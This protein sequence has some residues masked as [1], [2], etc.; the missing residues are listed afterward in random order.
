MLLQMTTVKPLKQY[1]QYLRFSFMLTP[2]CNILHKEAA[3]ASTSF[4]KNIL[5]KRVQI[6]ELSFFKQKKKFP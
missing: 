6:I 5:H 2:V 3:F 4:I 1:L